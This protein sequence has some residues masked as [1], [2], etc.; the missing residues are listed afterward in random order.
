MRDELAAAGFDVVMAGDLRRRSVLASG[1]TA[2]DAVV[3]GLDLALD[4]GRLAAAMA[5]GRRRR[6]PHRHERRRPLSDRR[7]DSC[8]EPAPR[9]PPCP[10]RPASTPEVIGKP[11]PAMFT[12]ILES[13][14]VD[15]ASAVV[16]GDNPDADVVAAKRAGCSSILRADRG[17]GPRWPPTR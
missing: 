6:A 7:R 11:A 8:P 15:G 13:A 2:Y 4:Y 9:W 16:I 12:A 17:G 14:G 3:V 10:R 5:R 1:S